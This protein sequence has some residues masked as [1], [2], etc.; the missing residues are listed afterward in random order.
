MKAEL[1]DLHVAIPKIQQTVEVKVKPKVDD[2][3]FSLNQMI[4]RTVD[5][6]PTSVP[7]WL[8]KNKIIG[9]QFARLPQV[10]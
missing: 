2:S 9:K 1:K 6:L 5:N 4:T 10:Y 3:Y 8:E 7:G